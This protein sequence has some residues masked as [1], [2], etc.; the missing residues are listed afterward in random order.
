MNMK[1]DISK[2]P[3]STTGMSSGVDSS[4]AH[5]SSKKDMKNCYNATGYFL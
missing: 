5:S 4:T 3:K 1:E 2:K